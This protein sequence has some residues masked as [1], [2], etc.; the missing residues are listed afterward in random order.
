M[1]ELADNVRSLLICLPFTWSTSI[2]LAI[3]LWLEGR[4]LEEP[5]ICS[6][7]IELW[8]WRSVCFSIER[9]V[10][11][12]EGNATKLKSEEINCSRIGMENDVEYAWKKANQRVR[13]GT[14]ELT[15]MILLRVLCA[16]G[17]WVLRLSLLVGL[18][19]SGHV[20]A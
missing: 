8:A 15:C 3:V 1:V 9:V 20:R 12:V 2:E 10:C 14:L 11:D 16:E 17:T 4:V 5:I 7:P 6:H 13:N 18:V 19:Y